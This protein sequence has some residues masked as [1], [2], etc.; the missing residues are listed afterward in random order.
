[1]PIQA[2]T[3]REAGFGDE[4]ADQGE[5]TEGEASLGL[6]RLQDGEAQWVEVE[7]GIQDS[8]Y[9]VVT[10]GVT[11]GDAIISGPYDLV[12]RSLEHGDKVESN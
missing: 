9:V 1:M 5:D 12:S 8:K 7:T 10:G 2:V 4:E 11:A 6:F 3:T